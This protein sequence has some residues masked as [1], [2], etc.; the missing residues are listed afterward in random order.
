ML[1]ILVQLGIAVSSIF[2]LGLPH[3]RGAGKPFLI[4]RRNGIIK[5]PT[6]LLTYAS[7]RTKHR[8]WITD[9]FE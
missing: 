5:R 1:F 4:L 9:E 6:L 7:T 3:K 8:E 2:L